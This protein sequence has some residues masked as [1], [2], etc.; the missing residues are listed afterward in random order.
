MP[1]MDP[2]DPGGDLLSEALSHDWILKA[3][4]LGRIGYESQFHKRCRTHIVVKDIVVARFYATAM[5]SIAS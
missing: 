5:G 4:V 3:R 2:R 1:T